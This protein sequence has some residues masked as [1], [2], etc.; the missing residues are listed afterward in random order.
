MRVKRYLVE[1]RLRRVAAALRRARLEAGLSVFELA[2]LIDVPATTVAS[3][4]SPRS[5]EGRNPTEP[6][7]VPPLRHVVAVA[8]ACRVEPSELIP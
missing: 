1:S 4:E 8:I 5:Y 7:H 6:L 3:Y 2:R